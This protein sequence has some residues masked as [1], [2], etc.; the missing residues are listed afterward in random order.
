[1]TDRDTKRAALGY[2]V[3]L[4]ASLNRA[5]VHFGLEVPELKNLLQGSNPVPEPL[6]LKALDL[7]MAAK[8]AELA[9]AR[10]T[11]ES[12]DLPQVNAV[13]EELLR[14]RPMQ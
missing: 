13:L 10:K 11:L 8:S 4:V 12:S 14:K 5:A 7:L 2:A 9:A 1:M 6:F 3:A